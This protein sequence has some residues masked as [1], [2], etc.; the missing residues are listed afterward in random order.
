MKSKRS[1]KQF[2]ILLESLLALLALLIIGLILYKN[3]HEDITRISVT[4]PDAEDGKWSALK[5]GIRM[6][7]ADLNAEI[8]FMDVVS[9]E[10]T[11]VPMIS[12]DTKSNKEI[13][14]DS[15]VELDDFRLGQ[16]LGQNLSEDFGGK[17][18]KKN[19]GILCSNPNVESTTKRREGFLSAIEQTN[20]HVA[21]DVTTAAWGNCPKVDVIVALDDSALTLAGQEEEAGNVHGAV[22][23]G[24]GHSV[25]NA[26][27]V[28]TDGVACMVVPDEFTVGFQ[29]IQH[30]M[31]KGFI[32]R[33]P[34]KT[35]VLRRNNL[36][37]DDIQELIYTM[38]Q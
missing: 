17:M 10:D 33:Q 25:E 36:Y 21:W 12:V 1:S 2:F 9:E 34:I 4:L 22:V 38:S 14:I 15:L 35:Y 27:Y 32:R 5:Y 20:V 31:K 37:N 16:C 13:A 8:S 29:A 11:A 7:A 18:S 26:Y 28:S 19:I 30:L 6:G 3:Y 23:Y 24:I